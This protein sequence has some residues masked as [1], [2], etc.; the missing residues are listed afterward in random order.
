M[1]EISN[2]RFR[3]CT[4]L[5]DPMRE[6]LRLG[7]RWSF[8]VRRVWCSGLLSDGNVVLLQPMKEDPPAGTK[9]RD[10]FLI[11]SVAITADQET[12]SLNDLV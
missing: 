1:S 7:I 10:K 3:N 2:I 4:E 11:Q 6:E 5:V 9:C 8:K 12:L